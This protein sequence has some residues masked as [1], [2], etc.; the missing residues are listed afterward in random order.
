MGTLKGKNIKIE[1]ENIATILTGDIAKADIILVNGRKSIGPL[2]EAYNSAISAYS[3]VI[4]AAEK[5]LTMA[6]TLG[7][8]DMINRLTKVIKDSNEA[9]K[10]ANQGLLKIKQL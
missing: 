5:Y 1:F 3:S 6:K 8:E 10:A 7:S 9:L 2:I 4:P